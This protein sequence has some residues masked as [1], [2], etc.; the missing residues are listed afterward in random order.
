MAPELSP[1]DTIVS[2]ATVL[3]VIWGVARADQRP[4]CWRPAA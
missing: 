3:A 2:P 4:D 1:A